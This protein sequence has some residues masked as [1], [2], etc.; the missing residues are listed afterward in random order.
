[1]TGELTVEQIANLVPDPI[2]DLVR[3]LHAAEEGS[4]DHEKLR[5]I[6]RQLALKANSVL[7]RMN[8]NR[9]AAQLPPGAFADEDDDPEEE[10]IEGLPPIDFR[11]GM[12]GKKNPAG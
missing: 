5:E 2:I 3:E 8:S 1:M 12:H 11:I 4:G 6:V 9:I 7:F 10:P